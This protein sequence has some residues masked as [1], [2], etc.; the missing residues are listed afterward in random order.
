M[1]SSVEK[2]KRKKERNKEGNIHITILGER[3]MEK[4]VA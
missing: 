4:I 2:G 1:R 3:Q